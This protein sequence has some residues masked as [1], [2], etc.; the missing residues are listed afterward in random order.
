MKRT[1]LLL[2]LGVLWLPSC[3]RN[4]AVS[5]LFEQ[6]QNP[7]TEAR[8]MVRWW[9]NGNAVEAEELKRELAVLK[10]VGIGGVEINSIAMP[11]NAPQT[12]AEQL[13]WAGEEWIN[14]V[15]IAAQE[16]KRLGMITDLI[17]GSGW[18]FGGRFL[19]QPEIMQ[20]LGLKKQRVNAHSKIRININKY[21]SFKSEHAPNSNITKESSDVSL[22]SVKLIPIGINALEEIIDLTS[23][24]QDDLLIHQVDSRDYELV[25]LYNERNF[26]TVYHGSPGADGPI[27]DHY[28]IKVVMDYLNRL[29]A[30]EKET[31][32]PLSQ[33]IRALFCDSIELAGSNWTDDMAE[34]FKY[35]NGYD[36]VPYLPF[37]VQPPKAPNKYETS[38]MLAEAL[39][40]VQYDFYHTI[41]QVF[42]ERFTRQFQKFCSENGVLCRY[43]AYGTPYY[44]GLFQGNM[45]PDIP[46][47]NNWIY[48][49]AR[50]EAAT[51]E[52]T[53]VQGHGYM[54]WNK[55]ASS[56]AHIMGR[57]ITSCEAMTNVQG[58]FR[59]SLETV[60]QADD[61]NFITGMN[62]AVLHGFNYSPPEAGFPGWVRYGAYFSEQNTWWKYFRKWTDYNARLS[63]VF[64]NSKPTAD[65][66][67][68]G[69][70]RDLWG[71]VGLSRPPLNVKP[72]YYARFW[73]PISNL[74]S[75]CDYIH[76]PI[77]ETAKIEGQ[78]LVCG[79]MRYKALLLADV[80][81][82]TPEAALKLKAFAEAGGKIVHI[83]KTPHRSLSFTDAD[84][85]D[86][87]V[88]DAVEHITSAE[89]VLQIAAPEESVNF[90]AWTNGLMKKIAM[91]PQV[92][93]SNPQSHLYITKQY[94]GKQDIYF[95]A[96]SDRRKEVEFNATFNTHNKIPYIWIP[97][98]GERFVL[99]HQERN[100]LHLKLDA[101][102]S[103][104]IVYEPEDLDL[105]PYQI[106]S[107]PAKT[108]PLSTSWDVKFEHIDGRTYSQKMEQLID[109]KSS[110]NEAIR[111]FA[112]TVTYTTQFENSGVFT[113]IK[114]NDVN[115]G[116]TELVVNGKAAGMKWYGN[117]C[118]DI[119]KIVK[120]G[121][122]LIEIKLTNT[123]ANYCS[124]LKD[125]PTAQAWTSLYVT[126]TPVSS[127]LGG[128]ELGE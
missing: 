123:L 128:V 20:R 43:Q 31:G 122:N 7:P 94:L 72:W 23:Q 81:S 105:P 99:P 70:I 52:F 79:N 93:I 66:A 104:L 84:K 9:W 73:Q 13:Q 127:G 82:L 18:P 11:T 10:E 108:T 57:K 25:F 124:S 95:F 6:F 120:K 92:T 126:Q 121:T 41:I 106:Q 44:M 109:F 49:G 21:L 16:G 8:P 110:E 100:K 112:G 87:I 17:V 111:N 14:M 5:R 29:K 3:H 37:V 28:Q 12:E 117:H 63:A 69:P 15:K 55:A 88:E 76:Q 39:K 89:N 2:F 36:I 38:P 1:I 97:A 60:K 45:I 71:D 77:L 65:M 4:G 91:K 42:L 116:I 47:S 59:T 24:V 61:M 103:V 75:S 67:I 102:E 113:F 90:I 119:S 85:N 62:H 30:I 80:E 32:I 114:L 107:S 98:T 96:N 54:L 26:K 33:L 22:I 53:W 74:G 19:Q 56:A 34:Q 78:E 48:S 68:L 35:R 58:V 101:L 83:G 64:Q 46:E 40:R 125:N 27:M 86:R 51:S 115:E 50:D 118:Y